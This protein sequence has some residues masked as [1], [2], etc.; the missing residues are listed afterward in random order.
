M[1]TGLA[2]R[3]SPVLGYKVSVPAQQG[4]WLNEDVPEPSTGEQSCE[5]RQNRPIRRLQRRSMDLTSEDCH[6]MA[7]HHDLDSEVRVTATDQPDELQD[8]AEGPVEERK[9]HC[10]MLAAW[11]FGVKVQVAARGWRSR[12][13]Q[14]DGCDSRDDHTGPTLL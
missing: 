10:R 2:V 9:C 12:H 1:R 11:D 14:V 4:L 7:Q 13:R 3:V 8:A 6:L 5:S